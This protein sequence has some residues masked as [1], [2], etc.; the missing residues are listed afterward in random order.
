M[1]P[2]HVLDQHVHTQTMYLVIFAQT[3]VFRGSFSRPSTCKNSWKQYKKSSAFNKVLHSWKQDQIEDIKETLTDPGIIMEAQKEMR[4]IRGMI[5]KW[6]RTDSF[7]PNPSPKHDIHTPDKADKDDDS[8]TKILEHKSSTQPES[9]K[10]YV[11]QIESNLTREVSSL[12]RLWKKFN[13]L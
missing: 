6:I 2:S 3:T 10:H 11:G 9:L 7:T 4:Q 12:K 13:Q 8:S 1:E 5:R